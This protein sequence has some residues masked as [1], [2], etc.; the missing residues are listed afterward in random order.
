MTRFQCWTVSL[1]IIAI[2]VAAATGWA[3]YCQSQTAA[4]ALRAV[5][6]ANRL[7]EAQNRPWVA[8]DP[9]PIMKGNVI[10]WHVKDFG[11]TVARRLAGRA[12]KL[13]EEQRPIWKQAEG[14]DE[15]NKGLTLNI[16]EEPVLV[17]TDY[18][19]RIVNKYQVAFPQESVPIDILLE[20]KTKGQKSKFIAVCIAYQG[21]RAAAQVTDDQI[22]EMKIEDWLR[23]KDLFHTQALYEI[24]PNGLKLIDV[25]AFDHPNW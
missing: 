14:Q 22:K 6:H 5:E 16:C 17:S 2:I 18:S 19:P 9:P 13:S 1:A 8:F 7:L 10:E 4:F 11:T 3:V 21:T 23:P 25:D 24:T 12:Y 15:F 20:D